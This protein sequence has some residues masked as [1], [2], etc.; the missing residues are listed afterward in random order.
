M[1]SNEDI[2]TEQGY[3][4]P[5]ADPG[6]FAGLSLFT[7]FGAVVAKSCCVLP[8][9][10]ASTGIGGAWL[11]HELAVF[12]SYFLTV[13]VVTLLAGWMLAI[14]RYR[15]TCKADSLCARRQT[16]W[17]TFNILGLSTMLVG[18]AVAWEWFEPAIMDYLLALNAPT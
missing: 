13:A 15:A 9:L 17:L 7:G 11:G 8:L 5:A 2:G 12:K 3:R 1:E 14:R 18:L 4:S 16:G 6:I 10:L